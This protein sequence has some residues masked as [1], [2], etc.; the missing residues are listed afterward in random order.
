KEKFDEIEIPKDDVNEAIR[1]GIQKANDSHPNRRK[2]LS[3]TRNFIISS[4]AAATLL[5]SSFVVPPVSHVMA[6]VPVVGQLYSNFNDLVG[7]NLASQQ[8]ITQL[9][10]TAS[11]EDIDVTVT[12]A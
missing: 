4:A 1:N 7:K 10:E 3:R 12:S 11:Y 2:M 8:Q 5:L 6:E 9:N